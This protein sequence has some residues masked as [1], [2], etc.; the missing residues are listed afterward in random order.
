MNFITYKELD[1]KRRRKAAE[2]AVETRLKGMDAIV[3]Q[4]TKEK[5]VALI[6]FDEKMAEKA[7]ATVKV[8]TEKDF[9]K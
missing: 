6:T 4:V 5:K 9:E 7:E 8:L 3:V 1:A 2:I